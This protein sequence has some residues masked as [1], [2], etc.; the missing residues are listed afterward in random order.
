MSDLIVNLLSISL[1]SS[2]Y[3]KLDLTNKTF[4]QAIAPYAGYNMQFY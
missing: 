1:T 3:A 2:M 4:G